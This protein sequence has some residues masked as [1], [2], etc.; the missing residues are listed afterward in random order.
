MSGLQSQNLLKWVCV[1]RGSTVQHTVCQHTV[2]I[3]YL[4]VA[5]H[6][7]KVEVSQPLPAV[8]ALLHCLVTAR[9]EIPVLIS[10]VVDCT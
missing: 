8:I 2:R 3:Q 5:L 9:V 7:H 6:N 1:M 10:N 4:L